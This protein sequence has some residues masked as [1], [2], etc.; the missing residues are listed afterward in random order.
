MPHIPPLAHAEEGGFKVGQE[1]GGSKS[2][3]LGRA[4]PL[5]AQG[6]QELYLW[7]EMGVPAAFGNWGLVKG[8]PW[9]R[10][11]PNWYLSQQ[12]TPGRS[13]PAGSG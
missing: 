7:E 3:F 2:H 5:S 8:G 13:G 4:Q 6:G 1:G 10:P 12:M 9:V 11:P